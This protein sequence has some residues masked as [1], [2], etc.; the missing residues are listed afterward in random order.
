MIVSNSVISKIKA[1][2]LGTQYEG[3]TYIAG[4]FVRDLVMGRGN[5]DID[6]VVELPNGGVELANFLHKSIGCSEPT[7]YNNSCGTAQVVIDGEKVEFVM[8]RREKYEFGNRTPQCEFGTI[9]EDVKRRDFTINSMLYN[10]STDEIVD[11]LGGQRDIRNKTIKTSGFADVIFHED[12]LRILRAIRFATRLGFSIES[13]TW[14]QMVK[15]VFTLESIS[16]ERIREEFNQIIMDSNF[17]Y[18]LDLLL[19]SGILKFMCEELPKLYNLHQG[20]YH[21]KDAWNHTLDVMKS[22]PNTL[23]HKMAALFH[24]SGKP[25]TFTNLD[26]EI[27]FYGHQFVS[28][29]IF[30][31]FTNRFKYS[32]EFIERVIPAIEMHM[33]F[34]DRMLDKTIRRFVNKYGKDEMLFICDIAEADSKRAERRKIVTDI[35]HFIETDSITVQPK[36]IPVVNGNDIM[37]RYNLKPGPKIGAMLDYV[38]ELM[39]DNPNITAEEVFGMIDDMNERNPLKWTRIK[40]ISKG[41]NKSLTAYSHDGVVYPIHTIDYPDVLKDV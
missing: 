34:I 2:I 31:K 40:D 17:G 28:A 15:M 7:V 14:Y 25:K 29:K 9:E 39:F 23:E 35:R 30:N 37:K 10:I 26:G 6:I 41:I 27:H 3:K 19:K 33:N 5:K 16:V 1:A 32:N 38:K 11:L 36:F 8:T 22:V 13:E 18:G 12:P 24:D 4:G 21:M 20:K